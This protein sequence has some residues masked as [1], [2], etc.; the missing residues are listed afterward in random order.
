MGQWN[1]SKR[2]NIELPKP[3]FAEQ[4]LVHLFDYLA[5]R[6]FIEINFEEI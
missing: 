6:K 4:I 3:E 2:S 5:S 1:T